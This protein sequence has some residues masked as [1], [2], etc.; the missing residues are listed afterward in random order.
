M[1]CTF[2]LFYI[3]K[4]NENCLDRNYVVL[5]AHVLKVNL[6]EWVKIENLIKNHVLNRWSL[7]L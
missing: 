6:G 5:K 4:F 1:C 3:N 2:L 7:L